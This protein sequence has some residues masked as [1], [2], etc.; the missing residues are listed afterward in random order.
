MDGHGRLIEVIQP[1][2][3][4]AVCDTCKMTKG[5]NS[6]DYLRGYMIDCAAKGHEPRIY[7]TA[8]DERPA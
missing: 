8:D 5:S 4:R 1:P 6:V 2:R 7:D 3:Y